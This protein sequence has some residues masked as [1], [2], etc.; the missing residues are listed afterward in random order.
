VGHLLR[1]DHER[2]WDTAEV[3]PASLVWWRAQVRARAEAA[4]AVSR[5]V[6]VAQVVFA[7][8]VVTVAVAAWL[9]FA[10]AAASWAGA[11]DRAWHDFAALVARVP[12]PA[13]FSPGAQAA[14]WLAALAWLLLVPAAV[15]FAVRE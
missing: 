4:Q 2:W 5:P 9:M 14:L 11:F 8:V 10:P 7:A 1:A 15:Y 3:P 12:L 13:G 6:L